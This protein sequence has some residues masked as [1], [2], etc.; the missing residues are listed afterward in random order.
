MKILS[1]ECSA[2]PASVAIIDN[3]K[4]IGSS[5]VNI[6][7]THSQTLMPMVKSL[8]D[9]AMLSINDIDGIAISQGP[10]SFTG[11]RIG[12]SAAKGLGFAKKLPCVGVSTLRSMAENFKDRNCIVCAVMDA[13]C[14]Q[15]YNALFN[16]NE[17]GIE[18]LCEDRALLCDE[19]A[20][21]I[22]DLAQKIGKEIIICGDG[23]DLFYKFASCV[24]QVKKAPEISRFQNAAAV[25]LAAMED[26]QNGNTVS[27][28]ELL[29]IY[30]RLPQAERELKSKNT[31]EEKI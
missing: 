3:G 21:E 10:G 9:A 1:L 4:I 5:F 27:A 24:S 17:S 12:I 15:V 22:E 2:S 23:A 7:L 26:F 6:K 29:P 25:G 31:Q 30:L 20:S 19:L 11:I 18:R 16:I 8:L 14:N 13:R 28:E